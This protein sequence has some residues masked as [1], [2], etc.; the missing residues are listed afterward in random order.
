MVTTLGEPV[1]F[2]VRIWP[3]PAGFRATARRVESERIEVFAHPLDLANYFERAI[4]P[5]AA[6]ALGPSPADDSS[7][8]AKRCP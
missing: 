1:V 6:A 2:V 8:D 4:Y 5:P 7:S 3:R